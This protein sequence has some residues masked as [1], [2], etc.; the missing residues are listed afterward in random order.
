MSIAADDPPDRVD[1]FNRYCG[2]EMLRR[3]AYAG[4]AGDRNQHMMTDRI[5]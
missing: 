1:A 5:V 3:F 2:D 4:T